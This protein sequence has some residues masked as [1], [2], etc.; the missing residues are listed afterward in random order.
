MA[1]TYYTRFTMVHPNDVNK[2]DPRLGRVIAETASS[3]RFIIAD[4][5]WN[6]A[7]APNAQTGVAYN[8]EGEI[9]IFEPIGMGLFDY[10]RAAAFELNIA[11]HLDARFLLEIEIL[12]EEIP[13][14][15][16]PFRYVFPINVISTDVKSTMSE[17]GT[18]YILRMVHQSHHAQ[19]DMVQPIKE[20]LHIEKVRTF[21]DYCRE[22]QN[23]LEEREFV[24]ALARQKAGSTKS[25]GGNNPAFRDDYHDE[26]HFIVEPAIAKYEL[27]SKGSA[28]KAVQ[29]SWMNYNPLAQKRWTVTA[30]PGTTIASQLMRVLQSTKEISDLIPGKSKPQKVDAQGSSDS[31]SQNME[32]MLGEVYR[33][34]RIETQTIYKSYDWIRGRYACKHVFL[35]FLADQTNMYQYPDELDLLNKLSNRD[36]V[37]AKLAYYIQEGLLQKT[38][39]HNYTGLNT[40]VLKVDLQFNQLWYL[41][42][43]P[44]LWADRGQTGPGPMH[45]QNYRR[46][47]SPVV[48]SDSRRA[49]ARAAVDAA[50]EAATKTSNEIRDLVVNYAG[51]DA[52]KFNDI[53]SSSRGSPAKAKYEALK[54]KQDDQLAEIK[55]REQELS[56]VEQKDK[57]NLNQINDR[58]ELLSQVKFAEDINFKKILQEFLEYNYFTLRPR[59]EPTNI[60]QM[61][62]IIK[63]ENERLIEKIYE[64]LTS[65][66]DVID[67]TLDIIGDPYWIGAPN[68]IAYGQNLLDKIELSAK[69]AAEVKAEINKRMPD[70]DKDW[71]S[72]ESIWGKY[73]NA[74]YMPA[75]FYKGTQCIFFTVQIP[76]GSFTQQNPDGSVVQDMYFFNTNDQVAGIYVVRHVTNEFKDGKWI[77]KLECVRDPTIPGYALPRSVQGD[78][79]AIEELFDVYAKSPV[80]TTDIIKSLSEKENKNRNDQLGNNNIKTEG[81]ARPTS[82]NS[83]QVGDA[84]QL[85]RSLLAQN[86]GPNVEDPIVY[87]NGLVASGK[88]KDQAY[89][90]AK[91]R[92]ETQVRSYNEHV[93]KINKTAYEKT[94]VKEY[95]PYDV[96]AMTAMAISKS[97]SGG[98]E[99]WKQGK[100]PSGAAANKNPSGIGYDPTTKSYPKFADVK[101]GLQAANEY[102]NYGVGVKAKNKQGP[103]RLL[104]PANATVSDFK[105][106]SGKLGGGG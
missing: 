26:Y 62:D 2:L 75:Q 49:A 37:E 3:G 41:P 78:K 74:E 22:L 67:L 70:I 5:T 28:D 76:D 101:T 31:N 95:R 96:D 4:I 66:N 89:A 46:E 58:R 103:D 83:P 99:D 106:L 94:G 51:G 80:K 65:P 13:T 102:F 97:G 11:N 86:P 88:S 104:L 77:Q 8:F 92:Y 43:F 100:D 18:E 60:D 40:D 91:E 9:K 23:K 61:V 87:A 82:V 20:T 59:V 7:V 72:K 98:L 19:T 39:F 63:S 105:Y 53:V 30:R 17:R 93:N 81:T 56:A 21:G 1:H 16:S 48:N 12:A 84:L 85:Q 27:T 32:D 6:H 64:V 47:E 42:S 73:G 52:T 45:R 55:K 79:I 54:K 36:K 29:G 38:Y 57:K 35:I 14:D 33:F 71:A 50:R 68:L 15:S 10:M 69:N 24:Y 44:V 90:A 25:P 34:F